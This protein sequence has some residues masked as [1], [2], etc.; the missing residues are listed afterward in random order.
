MKIAFR[1]DSGNFIG[2]GH[3]SRCLTIAD[4]LKK[5]NDTQC[6]FIMR[7]HPGNLH[8]KV[9]SLGYEFVCLPSELEMENPS[10]DYQDWI[11]TSW[12]ADAM[13][14]KK[15]LEKWGF[16]QNDI[17]VVD[18]YGL[19][20]Q[21]ERVL[22]DMGVKIGIIDDLVNRRH[23]GIFLVDQTMGRTADEYRDL[24]NKDMVILAGEQYCLLR[25]EFSLLKGFVEARRSTISAVKKLFVN[26]GSTDPLNHTSRALTG[27]S[28]FA[29]KYKMTVEIILS[30]SCKHLP[31]IRD[32]IATSNYEC[33]LFVDT[34]DV[35]Q[36][37]FD[38]DL[39]IGSAGTSTWER[40]A[41]GLPSIIIKTAENQSDIVNRITQSGAAIEYTGEPEN[42]ELSSAL[43]LL[44]SHYF[45][46]SENASGIVDAQGTNRV[47]NLI[48]KIGKI[49]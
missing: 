45:T 9:C 22:I 47:V 41:M 32:I 37:M 18:H 27:I 34:C 38:A 1:V 20:E 44:L 40:C 24:V 7:N 29:E 13:Q 3:L 36:L 14:S 16:T 28:N 49:S 10:S 8:H 30:S 35:A 26:F 39:A 33:R 2:G 5:K 25:D 11:G 43:E 4:E 23:Q 42:S 15:I 31:I 12:Q 21:W 48:R 6:F 17:T 46:I 19:D